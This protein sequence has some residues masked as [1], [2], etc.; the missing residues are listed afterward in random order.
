MILTDPSLNLQI[1]ITSTVQLQATEIS[2]ERQRPVSSAYLK[3]GLVAQGA[4][5]SSAIALT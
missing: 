4:W 5:T 1:L 2:R 3:F